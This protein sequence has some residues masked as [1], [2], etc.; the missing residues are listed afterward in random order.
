ME[1]STLPNIFEDPTLPNLFAA[2]LF[3]NTDSVRHLVEKGVSVNTADKG[4]LPLTLAIQVGHYKIVEVLLDLGAQVNSHDAGYKS[5][6]LHVACA[7]RDVE[8]V[9]LLIDR[10]AEVNLKSINGWVPLIDASVRGHTDIVR[11]LLDHGAGV[12][13]QADVSG[14]SALHH[15]CWYGHTETVQV[16]L[17]RGADVDL[18]NVNGVSPLMGA[19]M[20]GHVEIVCLLLDH[21]ARVNALSTLDNKSAVYAAS[22]YG[23]TETLRVLLDHG[24]KVDIPDNTGKT[25]LIIASA[26]GQRETAKILLDHGAEVNALENS[27]LTALVRASLSGHFETVEVLLDYGAETHSKNATLSALN[28]V[29]WTEKSNI[30]QLLI[31]HSQDVDPII[32]NIAQENHK[33]VLQLSVL[34]GKEHTSDTESKED[35]QPH[36]KLQAIVTAQDKLVDKISKIQS[37][38]SSLDDSAL[39]HTDDLSLA[40][41]FRELIPLARHWQEIGIWLN[42]PAAVMS[43]I[44]D[45]NCSQERDCLREVLEEWLKEIDPPPTWEQLVHATRQVEEGTAKKIHSKYC[46]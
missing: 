44:G 20:S 10:G 39:Q 7:K 22:K 41:A 14:Q 21:G 32:I 37:S 1:R 45:L 26:C 36:L 18:Q 33:K 29:S 5:T 23:Q 40:K 43:H 11:V 12:N 42:L 13:L 31:E 27:G 16:L 15:S 30:L 8:T 19:S 38:I 28:A 46:K 9:K 2:C 35:L 17:E 6:A 3:G 34:H 4:N 25:A 24:G